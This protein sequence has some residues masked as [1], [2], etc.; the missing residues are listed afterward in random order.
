MSGALQKELAIKLKKFI[1]PE[2]VIT[3]K[4]TQKVYECD[5]LSAYCEIPMLVVLPETIEQ[6]QQ[7]MKLFY[8]Y[9]VPVVARGA[10]TSLSAGAMPHKEG[11][12]LSLAK[13][14]NIIDIDPLARIA[15]LKRG[16]AMLRLVKRLLNTVCIMPLIPHNKLPAPLVATSLKMRVV[17]TA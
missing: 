17:C 13:F 6:V 7:A 5:G 9:K 8:E 16:Y 10:G 14:K 2:Y 15:R 3:D 11:V 12:V 1:D 4:E